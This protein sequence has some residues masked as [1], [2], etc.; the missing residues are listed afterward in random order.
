MARQV[1]WYYH[2]KGCVSCARAD[3]F[4]A[5]HGI[6]SREIVDGR[7]VKLAKRETVQML[8][9]TQRLVVARGKAI[10]DWNLKK[11]PPVEKDLFG[12][13]MGP[14]GTLRAP[15]VRCGKTLLVGFSD[16]AWSAIL[17]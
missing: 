10:H 3:A 2:R 13:I 15:S 11:E 1:D 7:K 5:Q 17:G 4:L 6:T 12:A 14:T 9:G 16:E 8:R